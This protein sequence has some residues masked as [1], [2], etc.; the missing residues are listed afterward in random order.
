[1]TIRFRHKGCT[2]LVIV[3]HGEE[4]L[5]SNPVMRSRDWAWPDGSR[6][7]PHTHLLAV[8]PDCESLIR[9]DRRHIEPIPRPPTP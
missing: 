1:M 6:P 3:Y 5:E 2:S 4:P 7:E 9:I 8:C